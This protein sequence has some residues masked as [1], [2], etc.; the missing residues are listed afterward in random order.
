MLFARMKPP[1]ETSAAYASSSRERSRSATRSPFHRASATLK[2]TP[3]EQ[4]L[5]LRLRLAELSAEQ[6][7][8]VCLTGG[9]A[10]LPAITKS[11]EARFGPSKLHELSAFHSVIQGLAQRARACVSDQ[12]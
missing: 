11:L 9:T 10:K 1:A 8:R 6:V 5:D 2:R 3:F 4:P 12:R 7:D